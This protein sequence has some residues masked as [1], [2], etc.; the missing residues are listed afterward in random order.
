MTILPIPTGRI[1]GRSYVL[2][3][4][5]EAAVIDPDLNVPTIL[6]A[7]QAQDCRL[8]WILL[9]HCHFDHTGGVAALRAQTGAQVA[10]H[11]LDAPGVNDQSVNMSAYF[12][13]PPTEGIT[14]DREL[15]EGDTVAFGG[16]VL[17]VL[18]TPGH[19]AGGCCFRSQEGNLFTGDTLFRGAYGTTL[20]TGGDFDALQASVERL[21]ALDG[22]LVIWPGHGHKSTI[23]RERRLDLIHR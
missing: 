20:T 22:D 15:N 23:E 11:T 21:Y 3:D 17:T 10:I 1:D 9:T 16:T 6:E 7:L 2:C 13:Q 12:R 8:R 14:V 5:G 4:G 19:T 18:H